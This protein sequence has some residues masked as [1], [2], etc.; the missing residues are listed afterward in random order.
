MSNKKA[1]GLSAM[2]VFSFA[3]VATGLPGNF[4]ENIGLNN[5][6]TTTAGHQAELTDNIDTGYN[7]RVYLNGEQVSDTHNVLMDGEEM[8]E[9]ALTTNTGFEANDIAVGNGT[10]PGD[11]DSSLDSEWNSC[12]L[13]PEDAG[14]RDDT[15]DGTWNYSVTY[16]VTCDDVIVNT[17]AIKDPNQGSDVDYF[18]GADLGRDINPYAGDT[19]TIEWSNTADDS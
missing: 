5:Q 9:Q 10:A 14:T 3:A 2:L 7:I 6:V 13:A 1:I 11:A 4:V 17:T 16:D 15:G 8:I 18:A 12:G 19:L